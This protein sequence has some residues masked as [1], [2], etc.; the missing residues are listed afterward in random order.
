MQYEKNY[1]TDV[2][3]RIDF[4]EPVSIDKKSANDFYNLIKSVLPKRATKQGIELHAEILTKA[5]GSNTVTQSRQN[6]TNYRFWDGTPPKKILMLE[7]LKDINLVFKIYKNSTE[8]KE[9]INLILDAIIKVYGDIKIKRT[10]LRYINVVKDLEGNPF[11]WSPFIKHSLISSLN[12][13]SEDD[14]LSRFMGVIEFNREDH[15][16]LFQFGMYNPDYPTTIAQKVFV[17]DYDCYTIVPSDTS[18]IKEIVEK[19]QKDEENCS[20]VLSKMD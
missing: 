6:V 13:R 5:D 17:L 14:K 8:L 16:V 18:E 12:F 1:L 7:P 3:F 11:D 19:L 10:G 20:K 9:V 2:I 4:N 15:R